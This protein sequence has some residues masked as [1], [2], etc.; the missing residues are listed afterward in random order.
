MLMQK[1]SIEGPVKAGHYIAF[2]LFENMQ[3][4]F[5]A[6]CKENGSLLANKT[7]IKNFRN[8]YFHSDNDIIKNKK[9]KKRKRKNE[10]IGS[11][12]R[13]LLDKEDNPEIEIPETIYIFGYGK[14]KFSRFKKIFQN[15]R[16]NKV[17]QYLT[18]AEQNALIT[19]FLFYN[20]TFRKDLELFSL[21]KKIFC[22]RIDQDFNLTYGYHGPADLGVAFIFEVQ[23]IDGS[24]GER[25]YCLGPICYESKVGCCEKYFKA[26]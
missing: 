11:N 17:N 26:M 21:I 7:I 18:Y 14:Q 13:Q 2:H 25:H 3:N 5:E 12:K 24:E 4:N 1:K 9:S 6:L 22:R 8:F 20:P 15:M 16:T 10:A 23:Y 19:F